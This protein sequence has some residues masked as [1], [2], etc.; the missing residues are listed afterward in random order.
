MMAADGSFQLKGRVADAIR[1]KVWGDV[2]YPGPIEEVMGSYPDV[3]DCAVS[4]G[5]SAILY[6][7]IV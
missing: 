2:I 4:G 7:E 6:C 5:V 3:K 1:Y